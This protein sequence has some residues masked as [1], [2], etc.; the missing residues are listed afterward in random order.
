M[1]RLRLVFLLATTLPVTLAAHADTIITDYVTFT[2]TTAGTPGIVVLPGEPPSGG[3]PG[4][5]Q[6]YSFSFTDGSV[7]GPQG[8]PTYGTFVIASPGSNT[9]GSPSTGF[10]TLDAAGNSADFTIDS[11][12][13]GSL[14]LSG[15]S[16]SPIK[17]V[18]SSNGLFATLFFQPGTYALT[19]ATLSS[20]L[21][22]GPVVS[23]SYTITQ[24]GPA[25]PP[26]FPVAP[27]PA[28]TAVTPEPSGL[29]LLGTGLLGVGGV[30]RRRLH[31]A[32]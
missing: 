11:T 24:D 13:L 1:L 32:A 6:Q 14:D 23:A 30:V 18:G 8:V 20:G 7:F 5:T 9:A 19:N 28:V 21:S 22:V 17:S 25:I 10:F 4:V 3:I 16:A 31:G 26:I 29:A 2:F 27:P 15:S 12:S